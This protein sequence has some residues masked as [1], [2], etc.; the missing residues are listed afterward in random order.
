MHSPLPYICLSFFLSEKIILFFT[1][2]PF[3]WQF[4]SA[5]IRFIAFFFFSF[6]FALHF[7][8]SH[9]FYP[10]LYILQGGNPERKNPNK[11]S[12]SPDYKFP[13]SCALGADLGVP[14]EE[15]LKE[16]HGAAETS[17]MLKLRDLVARNWCGGALFRYWN[18]L[19]ALWLGF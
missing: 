8:H 12:K 18:L 7:G 6:S 17:Q 13:G 19:S 2:L 16:A 4:T 3:P 10:A 14:P 5:R 1:P 15:A 9:C 11:H